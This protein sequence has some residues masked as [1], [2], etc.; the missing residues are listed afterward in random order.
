[1]SYISLPRKKHKETRL[2]IYLSKLTVLSLS[3]SY[4]AKTLVD[5]KR[6]YIFINKCCCHLIPR[7]TIFIVTSLKSTSFLTEGLL[8]YICAYHQWKGILNLQHYFI[9]NHNIL[10]LS[11]LSLFLSLSLTH[12]HYIYIYIYIYMY[13]YIYV[14]VCVC[15][16]IYIYIYIW[17]ADRLTNKY[18]KIYKKSL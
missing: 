3:Y 4:F 2:W 8:L 1:M 9:L 10:P 6:V 17:I 15:V 14:C 12:T 18:R 5:K 11:H 16:Y 7:Y 13:I